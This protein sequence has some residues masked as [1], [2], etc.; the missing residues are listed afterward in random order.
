MLETKCLN[1]QIKKLTEGME[2]MQTTVQHDHPEKRKFFK[3][4]PF[5]D[6]T[7]SHQSKIRKAEQKLQR[8]CPSW[9]KMGVGQ[10]LLQ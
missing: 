2:N 5:S 3:R 1:K 10:L 8:H 9:S 7:N 6:C 4:K